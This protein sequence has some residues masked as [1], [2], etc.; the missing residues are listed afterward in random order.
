MAEAASKPGHGDKGHSV[1]S[2][3]HKPKCRVGQAQ[4]ALREASGGPDAVGLGEVGRKMEAL[5]LS[6]RV[7]GYSSQ[8]K[9]TTS[10]SVGFH[11][12][13]ALPQRSGARCL[14]CG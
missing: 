3:E 13:Q 12:P 11:V 14:P 8:E 6:Q 9:G 10:R 1:A 2:G 5:S 4:E 7:A